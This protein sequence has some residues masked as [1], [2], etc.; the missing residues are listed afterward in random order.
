MLYECVCVCV[1]VCVSVCVCARSQI[2]ALEEVQ[3]V[4]LL[5]SPRRRRR[6]LEFSIPVSVLKGWDGSS[7]F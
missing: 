2:L 3:N 4:W 1:C 6:S 5:P 7:R